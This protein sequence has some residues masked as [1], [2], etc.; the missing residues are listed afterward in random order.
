[1][2]TAIIGGYAK[3]VIAS[4]RSSLVLE[5]ETREDRSKIVGPP[6]L[7]PAKG[8]QTGMKFEIWFPII[9]LED[10]EGWATLGTCG[11]VEIM[12]YLPEARHMIGTR[13]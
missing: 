11:G 3:G 2:A 1:M 10:N 9:D 7:I 13:R 6:A 5:L 12:D 8:D 4:L